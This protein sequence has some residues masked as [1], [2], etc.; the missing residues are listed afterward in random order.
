[1]AD[2]QM[3]IEAGKDRAT[4]LTSFGSAYRTLAHKL[5][6][7]CLQ[8]MPCTRIGTWPDIAARCNELVAIDQRSDRFCSLRS[9]HPATL[10]ELHDHR[11]ITPATA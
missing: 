10:D 8:P 6:T 3:D 5:S 9:L 4:A 1:M 2:L 11:G 7:L